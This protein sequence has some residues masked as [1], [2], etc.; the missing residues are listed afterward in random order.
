MTAPNVGIKV[1]R[2]DENGLLPEAM[3]APRGGGRGKK[4]EEEDWTL[5]EDL[6]PM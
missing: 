4:G 2:D 3:E 1:Q 6:L 5:D